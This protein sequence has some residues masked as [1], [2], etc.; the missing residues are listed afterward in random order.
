MGSSH[1]RISV[2]DTLHGFMGPF[3]ERGIKS[4]NGSEVGRGREGI[5]AKVLAV[6]PYADSIPPDPS[7]ERMRRIVSGGVYDQPLGLRKSDGD[8]VHVRLLFGGEPPHA[9]GGESQECQG[10]E[11]DLFRSEPHRCRPV[12]QVAVDHLP[13]GA[14]ADVLLETFS[15]LPPVDAD[16][17]PGEPIDVGEGFEGNLVVVGQSINS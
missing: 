10:I 16:E 13:E 8:P 17:F 14:V 5:K 6:S 12:L 7:G 3:A 9:G 4:V 2:S 11:C 15:C 1:F